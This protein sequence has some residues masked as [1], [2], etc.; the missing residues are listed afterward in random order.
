[1]SLPPASPETTSIRRQLRAT[2]DGRVVTVDDAG[3]DR[4]RTLFYG[5]FDRRPQAIVWP[6]S[7]AEVAEVVSFAAERGLELAVRGGGHSSAGHSVCDGG[8]VVDLSDL[9]ALEIDT[10]QRTAWAENGLTAGEL[11][12]EAARHGLAIGFGDTASVGIGGITLGG[13]VGYLARRDGLTIDSLL[14]AELVT[15]DGRTVRTDAG[16]H[17]ELFW[18]IRGG[19]ATS[20]SPPACSSSST[21]WTASSEGCCCC[22]PPSRRSPGSWPPPRPPPRSCRLSPTSCPPHPCRSSP[23][24]CTAGWP[25]WP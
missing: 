3:Y 20:G 6:T 16:T 1:M 24:R 14:A 10:A 2:V 5:G 23:P 21:S 11:T 25:S 8:I 18:A 12:T 19:G 15:A 4:A 22:P 13:G 17:P 7:T 9:K